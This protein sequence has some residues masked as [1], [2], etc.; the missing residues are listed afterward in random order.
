[1][2]LTKRGAFTGDAEA[3]A[4]YVRQ[5][6]GR[7]APR[8]DRMNSLMTWGRHTAWRRLAASLAE[9]LP[10]LPAL[11]LCCGTGDQALALARLGR[12]PVMAVDFSSPMLARARSK[13]YQTGMSAS[14]S[15]QEAG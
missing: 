14:V 4:R 9:P 11:D 7:I 12:G 3:K 8:Y 6:F 15:F 2:T 5:M 10:G 13:A 1:M